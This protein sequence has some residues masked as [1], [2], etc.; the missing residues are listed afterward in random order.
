MNNLCIGMVESRHLFES[1]KHAI[2]N[3]QSLKEKTT[4]NDQK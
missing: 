4:R 3:T 2:R 1:A